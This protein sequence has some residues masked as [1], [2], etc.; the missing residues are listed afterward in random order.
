M[1]SVFFDEGSPTDKASWRE[2]ENSVRKR[3]RP[4]LWRKEMSVTLIGKWI[5]VFHCTST[6]TCTQSLPHFKAAFNALVFAWRARDL[7]P[8]KG[9]RYSVP[10]TG[11]SQ[12]HSP[13]SFFHIPPTRQPAFTGC[14][15]EVCVSVMCAHLNPNLKGRGKRKKKSDSFGPKQQVFIMN[16]GVIMK[17]LGYFK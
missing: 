3:S 6:H 2:S 13:T 10:H 1:I 12:Q 11:H 9:C 5:F 8:L 15:E 16:G 17:E 4:A 7:K 14:T